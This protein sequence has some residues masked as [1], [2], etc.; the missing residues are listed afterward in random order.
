MSTVANFDVAG[1]ADRMTR[2]ALE[3]LSCQSAHNV[4]FNLHDRERAMSYL[5]RIEQYLNLISDPNDPLDLPRTHPSNY[6]VSE[7]PEDASINGV[8]NGLVKDLVRRY[9]AAYIEVVNSQSKDRSSGMLEADKTRIMALI[10]NS[11]G[12]INFGETT[13]DLPENVKDVIPGKDKN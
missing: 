10:D 7:F 13:L 1:I 3:L 12:I 11:K 9:K 2:F 6:P 8:E 4:E 5:L